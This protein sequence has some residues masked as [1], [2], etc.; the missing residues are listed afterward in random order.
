MSQHPSI[1]AAGMRRGDVREFTV[2]AP[3]AKER[4]EIELDGV[5]HDMEALPDGWW[6][7]RLPAAVGAR[8]G[9]SLDGGPVLPDP[10]ARRLPDGPHGRAAVVDLDEFSWTTQDWTGIDLPGST[11]YE[12]HVGTFT[13]GR[14]LDSAIERLDHL[15]ELGVDMV[16]LMPVASFP[17]EHG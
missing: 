15:V 3:Y 9:Y 16:E 8:Y 14:T 12:L 10:A 7:L 11:I 1:A 4:V 6:T 17:G 13:P 2:W 5:R